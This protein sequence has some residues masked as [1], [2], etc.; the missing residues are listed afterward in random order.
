[1]NTKRILIIGGPGTGKSTLITELEQQGHTCF[2][3]ISREVTAAAQKKGIEQLFLTQPLLFSELLLE[4]RIQQFND[5]ENL[6]VEYTFY[7]RG[8]PDVAAY[9][10]YT[11]DEYPDV[12]REACK[13]YTY[14]VTFMLA[15][16]KEIYEQDDERYESF[17]QAETIQKYLT[18]A[19]ESY[20]YSLINVPF[21]SVS[22]RADFILNT[23]KNN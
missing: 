22:E 11:G 17:E 7:D 21:G 8:I 2:H 23:L 16:W 19:Y 6:T 14:D 18:S 15:P 1:M 3:E 20:G 4:G 10:D 9:M 12:F 5:A 13:N